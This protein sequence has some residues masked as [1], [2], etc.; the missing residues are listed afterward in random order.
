MR[1]T[2]LV[3]LSLWNIV[4]RVQAAAV[5]AH[6]M[7]LNVTNLCLISKFNNGY[8][9]LQ[10]REFYSLRLGDQHR[11]GPESPSGCIC[12]QPGV[13]LPNEQ[14]LFRK[15][16]QSGKYA[17]FQALLFIR[18]CRKRYLAR[19]GRNCRHQ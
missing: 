4:H 15:R 13:Q 6:F 5:F 12:A 9:G 2:T 18:L 8:L 14:P 17:G 1:P 7:V 10:F 11:R 16:I 19:G 3:I